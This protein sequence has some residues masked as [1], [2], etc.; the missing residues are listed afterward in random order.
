MLKAVAR[1]RVAP[2]MP[3][4]CVKRGTGDMKVYSIVP[5]QR[6]HAMTSPMFSKM[7]PRKRHAIVPTRRY[8]TVRETTAGSIAPPLIV[9]RARPMYAT[10]SDVTMP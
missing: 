4:R 9:G 3:M 5:S 7:I 8:S 1:T 2:H 10:E 6:S